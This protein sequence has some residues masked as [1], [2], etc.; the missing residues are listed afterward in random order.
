MAVPVE[1]DQKWWKR[2]EIPLNISSEPAPD[3]PGLRS[4]IIWDPTQGYYEKWQND[5]RA[6]HNL[7]L[8]LADRV[9]SLWPWSGP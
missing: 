6:I 7:M 4:E 2:A 3:L 5:T 8:E 9:E 1:G